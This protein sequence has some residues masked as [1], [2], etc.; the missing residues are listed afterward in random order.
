VAGIGVRLSTSVNSSRKLASL[1]KVGRVG[2]G[3][4]LLCF[5]VR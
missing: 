4:N 2:I 1:L 3:C 5:I